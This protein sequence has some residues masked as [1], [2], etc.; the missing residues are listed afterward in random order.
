MW[1]TKRSLFFVRDMFKMSSSHPYSILLNAKTNFM[2]RVSARSYPNQL[3]INTISYT[4][5][6]LL[7]TQLMIRAPLV[8]AFFFKAA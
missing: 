6:K 7:P 2:K 1:E 4:V 8:V 5:P 3:M